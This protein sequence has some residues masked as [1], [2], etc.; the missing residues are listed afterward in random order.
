MKN[1]NVLENN[2]SSRISRILVLSI[3]GVVSL[4]M[5]SLAYTASA[6][7][8]TRELQ[9]GMSGQD[10]SDLQTFLA[11]DNTIYPEGLVTGYFG[12]LTKSAVMNFQA[13]NGISTVGRVGPIT[14]AAINSQ[15]SSGN[16]VGFD[17]VAP[18][19]SS[20]SISPL[21]GGATISWNTNEN[22]SGIVYYSASPI[23]LSEG[24][25]NS[26]VTVSG[27]S[28]LVNTGMQIAHSGTIT[29]LSSNSS[30]YYV[31]YVK[32]ASGNENVTWP[33]K[34]VTSQ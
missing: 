13:R 25:S 1:I 9:F 16:T 33:S 7:T 27:T 19:I 22:A 34:F 4:F 15:M 5:F 28:L 10:V 18:S 30:Y 14:L 29:G 11:S 17:K 12:S 23:N 21:S 31:I 6:A 26:S 32:D 2:T 20:I 3:L 8:L 24:T